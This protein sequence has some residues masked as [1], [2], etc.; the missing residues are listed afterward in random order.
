MCLLCAKHYPRKRGLSGPDP[1]GQHLGAAFTGYDSQRRQDMMKGF[2]QYVCRL[3]RLSIAESV[4]DTL[5][6]KPALI[7]GLWGSGSQE[8]DPFIEL[9]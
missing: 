7:L 4:W 9:C 5:A 3:T 6:A 2:C 8:E 1:Q